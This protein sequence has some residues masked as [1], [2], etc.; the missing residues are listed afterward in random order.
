MSYL[1]IVKLNIQ[2]TDDRRL[3]RQNILCI[4]NPNRQFC[5]N[6]IG[7][8]KFRPINEQLNFHFFTL[9]RKKVEKIKNAR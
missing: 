6:L 3:M 4:I 9:K 7:T 8:P 1:S 5:V 2:L